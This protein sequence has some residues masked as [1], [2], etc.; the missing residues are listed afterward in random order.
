IAVI[1]LDLDACVLHAAAT[2][3]AFLQFRGQGRQFAGGQAQS[4]DDGDAL[5]LA[6]LGFATHPYRAG[7]GGRFSRCALLADAF[8]DGA[9]TVGTALTNAGGIHDAA[10]SGPGAAGGGEFHGRKVLPVSAR[11]ASRPWWLGSGAG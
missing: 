8:T 1:A 6:A 10:V 2:A 5:A 4:G 9:L 3:A 11:R 7:A